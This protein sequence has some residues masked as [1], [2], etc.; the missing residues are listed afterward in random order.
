MTNSLITENSISQTPKAKRGPQ[1]LELEA[2][3]GLN[4]SLEV[5]RLVGGPNI[6][7]AFVV[8]SFSSQL[9][10]S[11]KVPDLNDTLTALEES[12]ARVASGSLADAK[13]MLSAQASALNLLFAE[14]NRRAFNNLNSQH[15][16]AGRAY[17]GVA[18]KAQN[19]CR[20]TLETLGNIVNPP[21]V[22]A[23]QANI[24]NGGQQQINNGVKPHAPARENENEPS[25]LLEKTLEQR[26]D[27]GTQGQTKSSDP[28]LATVESLHRP[29]VA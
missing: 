22:F 25:K 8:S 9:L 23:K 26:M 14:L 21:A 7:S 20:M 2:K 28:Q 17:L 15:F 4:M 11:E 12:S 29:Q 1:V 27:T 24:N 19:Q 16:E 6:A 3:P 13:A 10:N 18:L 5:A